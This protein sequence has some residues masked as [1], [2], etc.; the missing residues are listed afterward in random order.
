MPYFEWNKECETGIVEIDAQHKVLVMLINTLAEASGKKVKDQTGVVDRALVELAD[1][2]R[3]HFDAEE[4]LLKLNQ[5]PGIEG[6]IQ[7][8]RNFERLFKNILQE[9]LSGQLLAVDPL[10]VFLKPWLMQHIMQADHLYIPYV[11]KLQ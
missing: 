11:K 7:A 10:L 5:Y 4:K 8:H 1:Y 3:V 2:I 9:A 6:H